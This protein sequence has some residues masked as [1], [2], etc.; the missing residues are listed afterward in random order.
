M[1]LKP[2]SGT[3]QLGEFFL[4]YVPKMNLSVSSAE[5][6]GVKGLDRFICK[7]L[8]AKTVPPCVSPAS[9]K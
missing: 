8:F 6:R 5:C 1:G 2:S 9:H 7:E 4:S 3:D